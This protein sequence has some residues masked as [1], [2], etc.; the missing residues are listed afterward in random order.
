MTRKKGKI[1][2]W[3]FS[4]SLFV[5][6]TLIKRSANQPT[7][8]TT[9][10]NEHR[11]FFS[12]THGTTFAAASCPRH[13]FIH[14]CRLV[15]NAK[16]HLSGSL[17]SLIEWITFWPIDQPWSGTVENVIDM[18][19]AAVA[20]VECIQRNGNVLECHVAREPQQQHNVRATV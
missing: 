6:R 17:L 3:Q 20:D 11:L 13:S 8:T 15:A 7:T 14:K 5:H 4:L 1:V 18:R 10:T 16:Q 12:G 19:S 9:T 2:S